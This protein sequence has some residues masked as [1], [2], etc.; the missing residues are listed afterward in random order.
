MKIKN[1]L[2]KSWP[3]L[4]AA[5]LGAAALENYYLL[6]DKIE[7]RQK[8]A[9]FEE[10]RIELGTIEYQEKILSLPNGYKTN[11][12]LEEEL[13]DIMWYDRGFEKFLRRIDANRDKII[14]PKEILD[15][16]RKRM[17]RN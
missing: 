15:E 14:T 12:S 17:G 10:A 16:K 2:K 13:V 7:Y 9:T 11:Q 6:K 8:T 4:V 1:I 3:Y 5:A